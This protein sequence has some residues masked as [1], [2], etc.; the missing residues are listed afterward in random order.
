MD[1]INIEAIMD[2]VASMLSQAAGGDVPDAVVLRMDKLQSMV[3]NAIN[4]RSVDFQ[5]ND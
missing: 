4:G 5:D 3:E 2:E 1:E